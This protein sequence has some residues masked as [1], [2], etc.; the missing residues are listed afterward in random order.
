MWCDVMQRV[1]VRMYVSYE[2]TADWLGRVAV[3]ERSECKGVWG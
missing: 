2:K 1:Y 3:Y